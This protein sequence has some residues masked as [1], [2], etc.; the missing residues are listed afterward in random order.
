[1]L[2]IFYYTYKGFHDIAT[3]L[4]LMFDY[5]DALKFIQILSRTHLR[6]FMRETIDPTMNLLKFSM[7]IVE[8]TNGPFFQKMVK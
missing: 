7:K 8:L 3:I 4:L 2:M 1:M 6:E 5:K